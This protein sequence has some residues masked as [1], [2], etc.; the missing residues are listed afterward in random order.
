MRHPVNAVI[1]DTMLLAALILDP[2]PD[3]ES[4]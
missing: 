3:L 1:D 2:R 4:R